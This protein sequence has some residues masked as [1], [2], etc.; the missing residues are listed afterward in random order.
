[1]KVEKVLL[2]RLKIML[3]LG[4]VYELKCSKMASNT[5]FGTDD[6]SVTDDQSLRT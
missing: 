2:Y 1:M 6:C 3:Y 5:K 4:K